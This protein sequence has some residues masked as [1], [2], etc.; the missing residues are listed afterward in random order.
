MAK[1]TGIAWTDSSWN[2][3][4]GCT[5]VSPGCDNCYAEVSR[6][7]LAM[8]IHWGAGQPRHRTSIENWKNPVRW[9]KK[10][11]ET[12][13]RWT[14]FPSLCDPFDNEVPDEWRTDLFALIQA[15]PNLTWLLLTKRI[16]NAAKMAPGAV[17]EDPYRLTFPQNVWLGASVVNQGEADRDLPK[18]LATPA[19]LR[20]VS[21]EPALGPIDF[22][23]ES[24]WCQHCKVITSGRID[25]HCMDVN[26]PCFA[27]ELAMGDAL[28]WII[29]GGESNQGGVQARPFS[30]SWARSTIEQCKAA[31]VPCFVKQLGSNVMAENGAAGIDIYQPRYRDRSASDPAEW[32]DDLRVQEFPR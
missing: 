28:N 31:G 7:A 6:P 19:A 22:H 14:V 27:G 25:G 30:R 10:A 1:E 16:G 4:I 5:K 32:Q 29:V 20:F 24:G 21:Y 13:R 17:G 3:W 26:S 11:A 2:P 15:T 23:L 12:G 8:K 18:L 9:N